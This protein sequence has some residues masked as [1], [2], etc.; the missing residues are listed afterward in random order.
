[1]TKAFLVDLDDTLL[2]DRRAMADAVLQLRAHRELAPGI[3]DDALIQ[4]WD[5]V[6]RELWKGMGLGR[7][8]LV[9]QRR[10]RL[11]RVF[12]LELTDDE[13]DAL[14]ADYLVHY[15]NAWSLL[16]GAQEFLDLTAH[17]PRVIVTNGNKPQVL[18]KLTMLDLTRQFQAV[19]TP[20]DC[21]ARKPDSRMFLYALNLLGVK[22]KEAV[23]IGDNLE[24]DVLPAE[25]LGMRAFHL[26]HLEGWQSIRCD[27]LAV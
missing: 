11:R 23:M 21:A 5:S 20:E 22:P 4:L 10:L 26:N 17:L 2:D 9:E 27:I 12:E 3:E 14:F 25:A 6:G 19:V 16:P 15:E 24:D 8:A 7:I 13:A 1:M 18:R